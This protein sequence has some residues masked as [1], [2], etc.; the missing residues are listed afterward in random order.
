MRVT[1]R[2]ID[3]YKTSAGTIQRIVQRIEVDYEDFDAEALSD[4]VEGTA[5]VNCRPL[6]AFLRPAIGFETADATSITIAAGDSG[7]AAGAV[8]AT[9][10]MD[11]HA[12][13][14]TTVVAGVGSDVVGQVFHASYTPLLTL[15]IVGEGALASASTAGAAVYE[16][17][18][19]TWG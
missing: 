18:Y 7:V 10:V 6:A 19:E 2:L 5:I 13:E 8:A 9:Q 11:E 4:T 12:S 14:V 1:N 3:R 16:L 15:T 17:V